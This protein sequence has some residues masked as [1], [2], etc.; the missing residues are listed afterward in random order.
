MIS[1]RSGEKPR[2]PL[3]MKKP[4]DMERR[5]S[6]LYNSLEIEECSQEDLDQTIQQSTQILLEESDDETPQKKEEKEENKEIEAEGR[7]DE[8]KP[9]DHSLRQSLEYT[10]AELDDM[11]EENEHLKQVMRELEVEMQ[12]NA[13]A[14]NKLESKQERIDAATK[15]KHLLV[16]GLNERRDGQEDVHETIAEL[17]AEMGLS[18]RMDYDQA[19]RIGK[20]TGKRPRTLFISF[21]R[22]D[23]RDYVFAQRTTLRHSR[24]FHDVWLTED[25]TPTTRRSQSILRQVA[26]E[27]KTTGARSATT[28]FSVTIDKQRYEQGNL[29]TLPEDLS[30]EN[31]KTK[32][33]GEN[34]IA[35]H[36]EHA[37][38]SNLYP[39]EIQ[40]ANK[41]FNTVEQV[42]QYKRARHHKRYDIANKIFLSRDVYEIRQLGKSAGTDKEWKEKEPEIMYAAMLRKFGQNQG[43]RQKLLETGDKT[44][45]EATP[46]KHWG[47]GLALNSSAMKRGEY[48]GENHQGKLLM[49]VREALRKEVTSNKGNQAANQ[50]EAANSAPLQER[51]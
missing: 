50:A 16:E 43:L 41:E 19:Y 42:L 40:V 8:P 1:L 39:C 11:K 36:S 32:Q 29:D 30:L 2:A 24:S 34:M 15:K 5:R 18:Q 25:V 46:D 21:L 4:K 49:K 35:Y 20:Y 31:I 3:M 14:I 9:T 12:R 26:K 44:L 22:Q 7:R 48:P 23:A 47:S 33:I 51:S 28:L 38:F 6:N 45:V 17:L 37:P 27:A 13:Y 10:Q